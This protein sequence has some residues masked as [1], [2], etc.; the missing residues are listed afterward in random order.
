[1]VGTFKLPRDATVVV[2]GNDQ[3]RFATKVEKRKQKGETTTLEL[4]LPAGV[5]SGWIGFCDDQRI[6]AANDHR[7]NVRKKL[8]GLRSAAV[9]GGARVPIDRITLIGHK[10]DGHLL[11]EPP[12][13]G[14]NLLARKSASHNGDPDKSWASAESRQPFMAANIGADLPVVVV[15]PQV[16]D[17]SEVRPAIAPL[18]AKAFLEELGARHKLKLSVWELPWVDDL[19]AVLG[20]PLTSSDDA[21][22]SIL[23]EGLSR[24]A[25]LTPGFE[26]A[27]WVLLLPPRP[28]PI[29]REPMLA[30]SLAP[31]GGVG[32]FQPAVAARAVVVADREGLSELWPQLLT[33]SPKLADV[34]PRLRVLGSYDGAKLTCDSVE[35]ESRAAGPGASVD[36]GLTA[37]AIDADDRELYVRPVKVMFATRPTQVAMLLPVSTEVA[38]IELRQPDG[39][40]LA[41]L[42]RTAGA[43]R[44]DAGPL[45]GENL[46]WHYSHSRNVRPQVALWIATRAGLATPAYDLNPCD[47]DASRLPLHRF[48]RVTSMWL[49]AS[50]GWNRAEARI[51]GEVVS[52]HPLVL[53]RLSDGRYFADSDEPARWTLGGRDLGRAR[54]LALPEGASGMLVIESRGVVDWRLVGGGMRT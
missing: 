6:E 45:D 28:S 27:L 31:S 2:V 29:P 19:L 52:E 37:A 22:M 7:Q 15:R 10:E 39:T 16:V 54:T 13:N 38:A 49:T 32:A 1:V 35:E 3:R 20:S 46:S 17:G 34:G 26:A 25:M 23:L 43:P 36:V 47:P 41:R 51:A 44:L 48:A 40:T 42:T 33:P 21:R 53:R 8:A 50:D 24:R 5:E 12:R 9:L 11:S 4:V 14:A 18:D 30:R